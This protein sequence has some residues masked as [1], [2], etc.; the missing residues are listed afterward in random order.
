[1]TQEECAKLLAQAMLAYPNWLKDVG[2]TRMAAMV[3]TWHRM[4]A[5]ID[6]QLADAALA[7]HIATS[8]Y[9][10]T[11]AELRSAALSLLPSEF[12]DPDEAWA[13]VVHHLQR[14][15]YMRTPEWSH[16]VIGKCVTAMWGSWANACA[17]VMTDTLGVDR[18]QFIRMYQTLTKREREAALL[19]APIREMAGMLAERFRPPGFDTQRLPAGEMVHGGDVDSA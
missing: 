14:T 19:P 5:D 15:G 11:I 8:Q 6:Y 10:P 4:L 9:P 12:P 3:A 1:M 17:S 16:P 7:K 2:E 18:A 13:E